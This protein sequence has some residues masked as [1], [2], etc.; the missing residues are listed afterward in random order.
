MTSN[1]NAID[2]EK[3]GKESEKQM[4][5][6]DVESWR[7]EMYTD[8]IPWEYG[9]FRELLEGY[10]R[11]PRDDVEAEILK[12]VRRKPFRVIHLQDKF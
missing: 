12:I 9:R 2:T 5:G 1:T 4:G 11:I 7:K 8:T 6:E 10:S 3:W